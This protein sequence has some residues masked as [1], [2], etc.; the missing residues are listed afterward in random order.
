MPFTEN[1][2]PHAVAVVP[3]SKILVCSWS[4]T[5]QELGRTVHQL[6]CLPI[7]AWSAGHYGIDPTPMLDPEATYH[8]FMGLPDLLR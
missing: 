5:G 3:S 2:E 1:G 8:S 6:Y 4:L 7:R